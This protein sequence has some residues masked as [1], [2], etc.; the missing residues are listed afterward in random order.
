MSYYQDL[1]CHAYSDCT[2]A[3]TVGTPYIFI[4]IGWLDAAYPYTHGEIVPQDKEL[5][6]DMMF[7]FCRYPVCRYRGVHVCQ[8]CTHQDSKFDLI[9]VQKNHATV[10]LGN[11]S[12]MV[13]GRN[14]LVYVAPTLVYHY[15]AEHNYM[16]PDEF[17]HAVFTTHSFQFF[18]DIYTQHLQRRSQLS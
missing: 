18:H 16:P 15:V 2:W 17:I 5:L 8:Y 13:Q 12:I 1:T 11:G 9:T 10:S 6:L 14:N 7:E 4:N 3:L